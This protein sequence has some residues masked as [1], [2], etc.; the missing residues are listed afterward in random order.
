MSHMGH[1][2]R[3]E[4]FLGTY[5]R[6]NPR[7]AAAMAFGVM[8]LGLQHF[9]WCPDARMNGIAPALTVTVALCH[10]I[11]GAMVGPRLVDRTRTSTASRAALIGAVTSLLA[12]GLFAFVFS[13]YLFAT[14]IHPVGTVSYVIF[15]LLT[16]LFAFLADGWALLLVSSGVGWILYRIAIRRETA[17]G[18]GS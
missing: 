5:I 15:P 12:L 11:A 6:Q 13:V 14:D 16:A 9:A 3:S 8:T 18:H 10:A 4:D 2:K 1:S 17:G 7:A